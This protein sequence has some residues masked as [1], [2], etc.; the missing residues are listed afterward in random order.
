MTTAL[1][2][3]LIDLCAGHNL[4]AVSISINLEQSERAR[5]QAVAHWDG[6]SNSG[7]SCV[8]ECGPSIGTALKT[9]MIAVQ[10]C[11]GVP[12]FELADEAAQVAA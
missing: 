12:N 2:Q 7:H 3:S 1:E 10:K 5:F 4:T 11:R 9:A 8:I 6:P